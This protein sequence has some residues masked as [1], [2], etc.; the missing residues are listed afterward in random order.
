MF[1]KD[2]KSGLKSDT[3]A[4]SLR[5]T[6]ETPTDISFTL[7]GEIVSEWGTTMAKDHSLAAT[8]RDR[9]SIGGHIDG[10]L[11]FKNLP[12]SPYLK[13]RYAHFPGDDPSTANT[14]EA[15]DPMFYSFKDWGSWFVGSINSYNLTNTNERAVM[16]EVGLSPSPTTMLRAQY[17]EFWLDR[18]VT[19][20]AGKEWSEEVNIIFDWFPN[21]YFFAGMEFG[22]ARPRKAAKEHPGFGDKTT[23]E[24]V[25]WI[26]LQF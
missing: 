20:N 1:V 10:A 18:E 14:N 21:E 24:V 22:W 2:D 25:T 15:F 19:P 11:S 12:F 8:K 7:T 6:Y 3:T 26:G 5:V 4:L 17:Y 16:A 13:G 9:Q 23:T